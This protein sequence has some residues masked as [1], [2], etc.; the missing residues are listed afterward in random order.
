MDASNILKPALSRGELQCIGA[1]TP[2]EFRK[3]VEKT[4][5]LERRFQAVRVD[6]PSPEETLDILYGIK[7]A[8]RGA[9]ISGPHRGR[10]ERGRGPVEPLHHDRFAAGQGD[11]PDRR[12]RLAREA[13]PLPPAEC[14]AE[15]L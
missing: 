12:G 9:T 15:E 5:S 3:H 13:A 6:E 1:T 10:R 7:A 4:P 8:L 11:R 14:E 2:D